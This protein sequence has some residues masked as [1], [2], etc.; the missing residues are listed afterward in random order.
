MNTLSDDQLLEREAELTAIAA[1]LERGTA[2][3]GTC[4]T[5]EG[6]A[7]VGKTRLLGAARAIGRDEGYRV[8]SARAGEREREYSLGVLRSLFEPAIRAADD[9]ELETL[10][11]GP[12]AICRPLLEQGSLPAGGTPDSS[13]AIFNGFLAAARALAA[14]QPLLLA[15]DDLHW[16]DGPSLGYLDFLARRIEDEPIVVVATLRPNE[17]GSDAALIAS[18][19]SEPHGSCLHPQPLTAAGSAT[20]LRSRLGDGLGD[21][22]GPRGARADRRQSAAAQRDRPDARASRPPTGPSRSAPTHC[23]SSAR[24]RSPAASRFASSRA[25]AGGRALAEA[26]AVLGEEALLGQAVELAGLGVDE[27]EQAALDLVRLEVLMPG[28]RVQF[29]HPVVRAAVYE[30]LAAPERARLHA[31]AVEILTAAGA[32]PERLAGHL[33]ELDPAGDPRAGHDPQG[34]RRAGG[35]RR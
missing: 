26:A 25:G 21:P 17:P 3:T 19:I 29:V 10:W 8:L 7:G 12:A 31:R 16:V 4:L 27:A 23:T 15:I 9:A 32:P 28:S 24:G 34:G 6:P 22:R 18:L 35:G 2:G 13:F 14:E 5:L 20:A 30:S 11:S 33:L 1:L